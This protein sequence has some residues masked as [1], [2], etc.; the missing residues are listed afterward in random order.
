LTSTRSV[1]VPEASGTPVTHALGVGG[2]MGSSPLGIGASVRAW[3]RNRMGVQVEISRHAM[4]S[5]IVPDRVAS[6]QVEPALLYALPDRVSDYVWMRPY[7]GT[8]VHMRRQTLS[9]DV[10]GAAF[11]V[12][13]TA[14]GTRAFGG[15]EWSFSGMSQLALSTEVGYQWTR[16]PVAGFDT[17]GLGLVLAG[18]WYFR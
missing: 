6:T 15:G 14:F 3:R 16:N 9:S 10:P 12:S 4:S 2:L 18:H 8:G 5:A 13:E 11:A 17:D 7:V 1:P